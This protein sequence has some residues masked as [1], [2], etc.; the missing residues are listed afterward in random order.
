MCIPLYVQEHVG[1]VGTETEPG[2]L[3]LTLTSVDWQVTPREEAQIN[4]VFFF[5]V[6]AH[7]HARPTPPILSERVGTFLLLITFPDSHGSP[8]PKVI[9]E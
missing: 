1:C 2:G 4:T 8:K 9:K 6:Y 7:T 5:S 3:T